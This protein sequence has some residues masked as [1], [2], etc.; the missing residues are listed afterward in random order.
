MRKI[1]CMHT[2]TH[3]LCFEVNK[4]KHIIIL[5]LKIVILTIIEY[6]S[7]MHRRVNDKVR[8]AAVKALIL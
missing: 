1:D 2:C 4:R 5:P 6:S 3:D 8:S 7:I